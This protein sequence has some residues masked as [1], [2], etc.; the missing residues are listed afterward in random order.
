M[1]TGMKYDTPSHGSSQ[2][3]RYQNGNQS[4]KVSQAIIKRK[5]E[6]DFENGRH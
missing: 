5:K 3:Y 6:F 1:I 4:L 2:E